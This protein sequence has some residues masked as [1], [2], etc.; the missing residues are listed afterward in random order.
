[1]HDMHGARP[2]PGDTTRISLITFYK[3]FRMEGIYGPCGNRARP[4]SPQ[5]S[6]PGEGEL[7]VDSL[8]SD[9]ASDPMV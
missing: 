4:P 2:S 9:H 8:Q 7:S 3:S 6:P 5:P 1:M